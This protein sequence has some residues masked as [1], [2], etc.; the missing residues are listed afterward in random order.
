VDSLPGSPLE[1]LGSSFIMPADLRE[2]VLVSVL[3]LLVFFLARRALLRF[4]DRKYDQVG[5][6]YQ[7]G[8]VSGYVS[9]I[10]YVLIVGSIW[11]EGVRSLGTFLG[12]LTAGIAIALK[13]LVANLAGWV[14]LVWRRPFQVGDRIEI[15]GQSG[16]VVDIRIFQFTILEVGNWVDADQSTGRIVHVPNSLVFSHAVANSTTEFAFIWHEIPVL[17]TFESDWKR[18]KRLLEEILK[19][20]TADAAR[21]AETALA[22]QSHKFLI[23]YQRFTPH[24]YTDVRDSGVLLT[25]RFLCPARGRRGATM[26]IWEEILG[27]FAGEPNLE[28]AYPTRRIF[29]RGED[30]SGSPDPT[31]P[32]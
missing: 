25:M 21:E 16:D 14:F 31:L 28:L 15:N 29:Q 19:R 30:K 3:L 23:S 5:V 6:R 11:L 26:E 13:D 20:N 27:A 32:T 22:G 2:K 24:V 12:L 9:S 7:W 1:A 17:L 8:K 4:I 18:A 10:L